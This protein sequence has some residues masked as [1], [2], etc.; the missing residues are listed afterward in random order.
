VAGGLRQGQATA[1]LIAYDTTSGEWST[2]L[3]PLPTAR[4]HLV[5]GVVDGH[6][7]AISGRNVSITA[8]TA[9]VDRYDP[10][11]DG[12]TEVAAVPT[13]RGGLAAATV[14]SRIVVIGGEGNSAVASGVFPNVDV[15]ET[16]TDSWSALDA[17]PTPRHGMG[18]AAIGNQVIVP[19]GGDVQ[20]F[21]AVAIVEILTV[22]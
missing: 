2:D 20:A 3:A 8:V 4:E 22:D 9:R 19:G 6:F 18:A 5:G 17:M 10:V 16:T 1:S 7:Y 21:G 15:Y 14:D 13:G 11:T 12:W